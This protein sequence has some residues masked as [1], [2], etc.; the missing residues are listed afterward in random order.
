MKRLVL[1]GFVLFL[2]VLV[3]FGGLTAPTKAVF[4]LEP[5]FEG[6][7]ICLME[8]D[9][10]QILF[11]KNADAHL[12]IASI[13]KLMTILITMEQIEDGKLN[14]DD[15]IVVSKNAA[16]MGGSQVFIDAG[17]SYAVGDMLKS[18]IVSSANDASVALAEVIAGT[19]ENFVKI[20]NERAKELKLDNTVFANSTGL[21]ASQYSCA[22]DV[23]LMLKEVTSHEIYHNYSTI[24]MD[25]L[26]HKGGR[27]TELVN[28]NKLIRY[29][30]GCDGGKTGSTNEAGYCLAASAKRGDMRLI[31]VVLGS[32][33]GTERFAAASALLSF[34]FNNYENKIMIEN[35]Q[36]LQAFEISG[37]KTPVE[38]VSKND[39]TVLKE[40]NDNES[41]STKIDINKNLKAPINKGDTVGKVYII[42]G[43][44]VVG[45]SDLVA[46][47]DVKR[48]KISDNIIKV[49]REWAIAAK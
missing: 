25:K 41:L 28:T 12:P 13:V 22:K 23:A 33:T 27:E 19:E 9:S 17:S 47:Q 48:M 32:K 6:K 44:I 39:I 37:G 31:G 38:A 45:E 8:Y 43:G 29:F 15:M 34:G 10:N 30:E 36:T 18:V 20:M 11:E 42:K 46:K 35:D 2:G 7:A 5:D 49:T 3:C 21:P 1:A 26:A 4:A 40:K 16:G 14:A 24:W